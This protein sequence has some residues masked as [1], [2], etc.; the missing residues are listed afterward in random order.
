MGHQ[1]SRLLRENSSS[2]PKSFRSSFSPPKP[3]ETLPNPI[4][5]PTKPDFFQKIKIFIKRKTTKFSSV[6]KEKTI[7]TDV[8]K[9]KNKV[10]NASTIQKAENTVEIQNRR[11]VSNTSKGKDQTLNLIKK[12]SQNIMIKDINLMR[13]NNKQRRRLSMFDNLGI[14]SIA[15]KNNCKM[16][17][18]LPFSI[19]D[20]KNCSILMEQKTKSSIKISKSIHNTTKEE[21]KHRV[22]FKK[23]YERS[24]NNTLQTESSEKKNTTGKAKKLPSEFS[25]PL[26]KTS[27][28][29]PI[30]NSDVS[31]LLVSNYNDYLMR[32][33]KNYDSLNFDISQNK[34]TKELIKVRNYL[35]FKYFFL[36]FRLK[37]K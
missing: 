31:A 12:K 22:E 8:N 32:K 1:Q 26:I 29:K 33:K 34:A 5:R 24:V 15:A 16:E 30:I 6:N 3:V 4:S 27:I 23:T 11:S 25:S 9:N 2:K 17:T 19:T 14:T 28:F 36:F 35:I 21:K 20:Q 18:S 13:R 7:E 37:M 10:R